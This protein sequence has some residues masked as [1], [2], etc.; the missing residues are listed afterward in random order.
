MYKYSIVSFLFVFIS[1]ALSSA[2]VVS[3]VKSNLVAHE[4]KI[5]AAFVRAQIKE[6]F[7][8]GDFRAPLTTAARERMSQAFSNVLKASNIIHIN[9]YDTRA[10]IV[11]SSVAELI[12]TV[13][14]ENPDYLESLRGGEVV[15]VLEMAGKHIRPY[16]EPGDAVVIEVYV[17]VKFRDTGGVMGVA[18]VYLSATPLFETIQNSVRMVWFVIMSTGA[19]LYLALF[20]IFY[21]SY[22]RG[23]ESRG[24][25]ERLNRELRE[26]NEGLEKRVEESAQRLARMQKL[27]A[28]GEIMGEIAHQL[29]NPLVGIVNFA[30]LAQR[31]SARGDDVGGELSTIERSGLECKMI[32]QKILAFLRKMKLDLA[33]T[34]ILA[35][36][37]ELIAQAKSQGALPE[38]VIEKNA[39]AML[40]TARVDAVLMRQAFWNIMENAAQAMP[41][42]GRLT[43]EVVFPAPV[44]SVE[45]ML[46]RFTDSGEGIAPGR[47]AE[48]FSPLFTTK[49][50]GVGLGL[51]LTREIITRHGGR[52]DVESRVG[53]G[54]TFSVWLPLRA[55][56]TDETQH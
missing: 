4:A 38:I 52:V 24:T 45:G 39:P 3:L 12:G 47:L 55:G 25:V 10:T 48:I 5:T 23:E 44:D 13:R 51:S 20:Y 42:G 22:R 21:T 18:G 33:D 35:L 37:D 36:L 40:P 54:T 15:S 30:Q 50:G 1:A 27:S 53:V 31:K 6:H 43:V 41:Q 11:W 46:V 26:V 32:I 7:S 16:L 34:D 8:E 2:I 9:V 17:P 49:T 19:A 29:N 56:D 14:S 28:M